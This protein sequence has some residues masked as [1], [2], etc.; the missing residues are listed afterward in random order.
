MSCFFF[1]G[2]SSS[3]H[4][5]LASLDQLLAAEFLLVWNGGRVALL[6]GRVEALL[7]VRWRFLVLR[8]LVGN[9]VFVAGRR[10][11][12]LFG[13]R[14]VATVG[15]FRQGGLVFDAGGRG[16]S[17]AFLAGRRGFGVVG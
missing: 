1:S 2:E 14:S 13:L 15:G 17:G 3:L 4:V 6:V 7:L 8:L 5:A 16:R 10:D 11:G 12:F 9:I